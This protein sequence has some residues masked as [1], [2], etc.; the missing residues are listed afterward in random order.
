MTPR[1]LLGLVAMLPGV[2]GL[3]SCILWL[4]VMAFSNIW[5]TIAVLVIGLTTPFIL[6][7]ISRLYLWGRHQW[8]KDP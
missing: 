2:L 7:A 4:G 6:F 3:A 1:K 5:H 8:R